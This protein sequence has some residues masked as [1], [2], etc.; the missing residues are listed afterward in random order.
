MSTTRSQTNGQKSSASDPP[1]SKRAP[2]V[3]LSSG[4]YRP[5]PITGWNSGWTEFVE[6]TTRQTCSSLPGNAR[7]L[8]GPHPVDHSASRQVA[9]LPLS[10]ELSHQSPAA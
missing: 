8:D 9:E 6:H 1:S 4:P 2:Q 3:K 7:D 10:T 5:T